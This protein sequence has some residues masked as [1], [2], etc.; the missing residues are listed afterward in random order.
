M[1]RIVLV[2]VVA[3]LVANANAS[4]VVN[5]ILGS[6]SGSDWEFIE[7]YNTSASPIDISGYEVELWDSD[8]GS[9]GTPDGQ[10]PYVVPGGSTIPG[11]GFYL[12]A[13]SLAET[14]FSVTADLP[15]PSNAIENSAYTLILADDMGAQLDSWF[16][17]QEPGTGETPNRAGTPITPDF[18]VPAFDGGSFTSVQAGTYRTTDG[19]SAF[20]ILNFDT[21]DLGQL[22]GQFD[23]ARGTPGSTN[24]P[25]PASLL[26][27]AMAGLVIRRR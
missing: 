21:G 3:A 24:I 17:E 9:I 23:P 11:N 27:L 26:L 22:P 4:I 15:L 6:T 20:G 2:A 7:L 14:G 10:S 18:F 16:F 19:G 8:P 5:E 1:N 13:N 12:M 25:E